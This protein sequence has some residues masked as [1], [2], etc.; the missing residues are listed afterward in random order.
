M[1]NPRSVPV[2][3]FVGRSGV[4]KTAALEHVI[5]ELKR[6]G[7]RVGTIKHDAHDFDIDRPG[8]DSWRHGQAGSDVVVIAGPRRMAMIRKLDQELSLDD[9]VPLMGDLDLVLT[10]GYKRGDR[11]KVEVSRKACG[12]DLLCRAEELVGLMC[13][14]ES[15]MPVPQFGLEDAVGVADLLEELFVRGPRELG[16]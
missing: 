6:R 1:S 8:K 7:L 4:G 16:A 15:D 3:S 10:E 14:Y 13:D 12:T 2:I 11:P 9:L 5:R